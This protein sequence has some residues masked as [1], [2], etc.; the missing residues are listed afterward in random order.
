MIDDRLNWSDHINS[1]NSKISKINGI[2]YRL[3]KFLN[4]NTLKI[5]YNSLFYPQ[6]QY[7]NIA[8]G[9]AAIKYLNRLIVSQKR[10]IRTISHAEYL[11]PTNDLFKSHKTLK[12][13]DI[14]LLECVKFVKKELAR[15]N[16]TFFVQRNNEHNMLLRN[17]NQQLLNLPR[18]RSEQ[19]RK[20]VTYFGA[21]KWNEF[22]LEI[23]LKR[24]PASFKIHAKKYLISQ[25]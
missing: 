14:H 5:I 8:W 11:Q 23:R 4:T 20:F 3:S 16:T 6:L 25:Y 13:Q 1:V 12:L 17:N 22:P 24:T 18:P 7:G 10:A 19:A 2:L 9:N 15:P 21:V